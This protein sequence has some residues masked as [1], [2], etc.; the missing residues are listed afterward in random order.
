[1]DEFSWSIVIGVEWKKTEA[2]KSS[3][4]SPC[5][6]FQP[7]FIDP[8]FFHSLFLF[9]FSFFSFL[10]FCFCLCFYFFFLLIF[11]HFF[12]ASALSYHLPLHVQVKGIEVP[13]ALTPEMIP[14]SLRSSGQSEIGD[15]KEE[16]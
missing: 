16:V 6:I 10:F 8:P 9:L 7:Y 12:F 15:C 4:F 3:F 11:L 1:M 5:F 14:P 13:D 2:G